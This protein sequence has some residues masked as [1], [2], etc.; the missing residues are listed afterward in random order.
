MSGNNRFIK[1]AQQPPAVVSRGEIFYS[2]AY[3]PK[4]SPYKYHQEEDVQVQDAKNSLD[5]GQ[6]SFPTYRSGGFATASVIPAEGTKIP[7]SFSSSLSLEKWN[8]R[9]VIGS[10]RRADFN[11]TNEDDRTIRFQ[12]GIKCTGTFLVVVRLYKQHMPRTLRV[13]GN[14]IETRDSSIVTSVVTRTIQVCSISCADL[15]LVLFFFFFFP[16]CV[17][18][19]GHVIKFFFFSFLFLS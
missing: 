5:G 18:F 1:I 15:L 8:D 4:S 17:I 7:L 3:F 10:G 9:M 2:I 19:A 13:G 12:L 16:V 14:G 6:A 11:R